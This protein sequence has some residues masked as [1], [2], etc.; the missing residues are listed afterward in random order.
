MNFDFIIVST[1]LDKN[2]LTKINITIV[3]FRCF[4]LLKRCGF[5]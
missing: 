4:N 2:V 3:K 1:N 5:L